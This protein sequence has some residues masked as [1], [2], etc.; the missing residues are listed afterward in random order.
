MGGGEHRQHRSGRAA[1]VSRAG[2]TT[3]P[4][5]TSYAIAVAIALFALCP[6]IVLS[7]AS[8]AIEPS[9]MGDL[10]ASRFAVGLAGALANAGYAFGAVVAAELVRRVP[11]RRV[12][13]A[14]ELGFALGS[15]AALTAPNITLFVAGR[16]LQGLSTGML[17]VS[18][19]PPLVTKHGVDKL[20]TTAAVASLGLFGT[21]TLGPL[22]GG[23]VA[24]SGAWRAL[25]AVAAL[26]GV[27]GIAVGALG[28]EST[29][30]T[31]GE[32]DWTAMPLALAA[33]A[34][35]FFG[36]SWL[37]HS[38]SF[39]S[40]GFVV[41]LA[42]GLVAL[43]VL[44]VSQYRKDDALMPVR[45]IAHTLPVTGITGA[46][47]V[48]A[49]V[50]GVGELAALY[51]TKVSGDGALTVGWLVTSQVAGAAVAAWLFRRV[52]P[53]RWLPV[54]ALS[55]LVSV[56]VGGG[57]LLW[58][59]ASSA[60]ALVPV[61]SFFLGFGAGAGVTPALF[62]VGLSVPS[63]RLPPTFALVELL[64]SAAAFLL[65]PVLLELAMSARSVE[66]GV[67]V[68]VLVCIGLVGVVAVAVVALYALGGAHLQQP[69]LRVWVDGDEPAYD[70]PPLAA[71]V[72]TIEP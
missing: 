4:L 66:H 25:F 12:Y 56:A 70:S 10:G 11:A 5:R 65:A 38:G 23:L 31:G 36:V 54:L 49:T 58:L 69:D 57:M 67:H 32:F 16:T 1:A 60:H 24:G 21:V 64:R 15:L 59:S 18:A 20:P 61:A 41:P 40:P 39:S 71:E 44:V 62:M 43:V 55:G 27:C 6:F 63:S 68:G 2:V 33:T 51:L 8:T 3:A 35:P 42:V 14:C 72:R 37:A 7:S 45:P 30:P 53:T 22:V 19:L 28:F 52:L 13:L 17:L 26:L 50:T 34:L 46:M 48:G 29:E 47:A 9:L